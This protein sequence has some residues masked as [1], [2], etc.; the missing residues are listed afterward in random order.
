[1][2]A[3]SR[4]AIPAAGYLPKVP[5]ESWLGLISKVSLAKASGMAKCRQVFSKWADSKGHSYYRA[6]LCQQRD[7]CVT[8]S[9]V[10]N[11]ELVAGTLELYRLLCNVVGSTVGFGECE[12]TLPPVAQR[13]V[14]D[15]MLGALRRTGFESINEV[16]SEQSRLVLGG[17]ASTHHW[18]SSRPLRGWFPHVHLTVLGLAYEKDKDRFVP[19][20]LYFKGERLKGLNKVWGTKFRETFDDTRTRKFVTHWHY[21]EGYATAEHRFRYQFR[22]PVAETFN[23]VANLRSPDSV[24]LE[25]VKRMLVRPRNE[26]RHQWYGYLS[27]GIKSKYIQ[28]LGVSVERKSVGDRARRKVYCPDCGDELVCVGHGIP[29]VE[30]TNEAGSRV[31]AFRG[32]RRLGS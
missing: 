11:E 27:D 28:K 5:G 25:W 12:L 31:L 10:Y 23:A 14:G 15:G 18:H 22:R 30:L 1:M 20:D 6:T 21:G 7:V 29:Y 8:C 13:L 9:W 24:N 19:L 16:L 17:V 3:G 4:F 32:R 2:N 26:K